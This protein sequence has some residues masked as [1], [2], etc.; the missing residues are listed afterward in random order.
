MV[1]RRWCGFMSEPIEP[2]KNPWR[3]IVNLNATQRLTFTAAFLGWALDAFDFFTVVLTVPQIAQEFGLGP[4]KIASAITVTL[5]LRPVGAI[6]FGL[7]ADRYG[8]R[9]PLMGNIFL[10]SLMEFLTGFAPNFTV[11]FALRAVFGIAMGGE[12]GLGASLA[13]E[14]LPTEA[15]GIFSGILQQGYSSG[16]LLASFV[17]FC[18]FEIKPDISWR[19]LFYIG[20]SPALLILFLRFF[21][22]ESETFERQK[23]KATSAG[24]YMKSLWAMLKAEWTRVLY[25]IVL[26]ACFNFMSHGSQDLYPT[27]LRIQMHYSPV[28]MSV[29][30]IVASFGAIIGGTIIGYF[31]Q[32]FGRRRTIVVSSLC[33]LLFVPLWVYGP[34]YSMALG[35]FGLQF[36]VQGAWGVVPVFLNEISPG[37]FRGTFPGVVYQIGNLIS[38]ASAQ[39][40]AKIGESFPVYSEQDDKM[41][42]DYGKT[43]AIFMLVVFLSISFIASVGFEERGKDFNDEGGSFQKVVDEYPM[44]EEQ[45]YVYIFGWRL[46]RLQ[47][48][49][50]TKNQVT[51][52]PV[53]AFH[54]N[55]R[56][57][58]RCELPMSNP[59]CL[60]WII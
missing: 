47:L 37:N 14:S 55:Q 25:G 33:G 7:L 2:M 19:V 42:A 21:V 4:A 56:V 50:F 41:I 31:S 10:Y 32:Y 60:H 18:L 35:A 54:E 30:N 43:Q 46:Y 16:H 23:D 44:E 39:I 24:D 58:K 53:G 1:F 49:L 5:M 51:H 29:T 22:P 9:Y 11:F 36:F 57:G 12:W 28:R 40:Q 6:I 3:L 45:E 38:A 13:M 17:L 20:A 8:R 48:R 27:F 26:M 52:N 15:R 59:S 34:G